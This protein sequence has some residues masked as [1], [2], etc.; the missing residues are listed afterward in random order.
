MIFVILGTQ[1]KKFTRLLDAIQKKID[2]GK[3]SKKEKIIVQAGCTRYKS[4]NMQIIDY[5]PLREF[6]DYVD[7]ADII[8]CHA[9]VGTILTALK[10]GKKIIAAARLKKYG[11][12]VNDH[13]K[14]IEKKFNDSG[15]LI[16]IDDV[17]DLKYAI[18][19]SERFYPKKYQKNNS[20]MINIIKTYIDKI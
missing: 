15:L 4:K 7:K 2:E 10:K 14:D 9:G 17:N 5:M 8:I 11:E 16:G 19:K 13:Q 12:H 18:I 20:E 3:I 6:E 1:D